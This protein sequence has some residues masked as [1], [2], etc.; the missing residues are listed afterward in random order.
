MFFLIAFPFVLGTNSSKLYV[1]PDECVNCYC[2]LTGPVELYLAVGFFVL[3]DFLFYKMD[4]ES[5]FSHSTLLPLLHNTANCK[6]RHKSSV[7]FKIG[8]A[9]ISGLLVVKTQLMD[10]VGKSVL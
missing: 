5:Y 8:S 1:P 7:I 2:P 3:F 10:S 9:T 6:A 4:S